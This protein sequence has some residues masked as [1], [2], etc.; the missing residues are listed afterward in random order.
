MEPELELI[1]PVARATRTGLRSSL[2]SQPAPT[3]QAPPLPRMAPP[4]KALAPP[5]PPAAAGGFWKES[6]RMSGSYRFESPTR[7]VGKA[8]DLNRWGP[9]FVQHLPGERYRGRFETGEGK[10]GVA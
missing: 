3:N 4:I 6:M 2:F 10:N 7:P 8:L 5:L 1:S 9:H